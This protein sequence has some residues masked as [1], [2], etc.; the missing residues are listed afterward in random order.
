MVDITGVWF[1]IIWTIV[2]RFQRI[3]LFVWRIDDD[4]VHGDLDWVLRELR[5]V[6]YQWAIQ[7]HNYEQNKFTFNFFKI[8]DEFLKLLSVISA[9]YYN[10]YIIYPHAKSR[11]HIV[12]N[13]LEYHGR[14]D[15]NLCLLNV[16]FEV[17]Q[18]FGIEA[19]SFWIR[20]WWATERTFIYLN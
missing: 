6:S 8:L 19:Y 2:I 1:K 14:A 15:S 12:H 9:N 3:I 5:P 10:V 7:W 16:C 17:R 11:V 18:G 13:V 4:F 20:R